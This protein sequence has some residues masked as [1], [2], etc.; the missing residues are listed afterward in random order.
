MDVYP[1][2]IKIL[3]SKLHRG[4]VT[5]VKLHYPGSIA[6]DQTLID[7]AGLV[8][9]EAVWVADLNNGNRVQ[10]YVVPA[11]ANSGRIDILG[12]A[13]QRIKAGDIVIIMAFAYCTPQEAGSIKPKVIVLDGQNRIIGG[14]DL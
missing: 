9:Y 7:A 1:M 13:A 5:A 14:L 12:A 10:T 4:V 3:K 6:V 11:P 2:F 8:P